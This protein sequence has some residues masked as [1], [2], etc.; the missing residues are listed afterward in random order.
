MIMTRNIE[1]N[2]LNSSGYDLLYPKTID[3]NTE[4]DAIIKEIL[5][6][7]ESDMLDDVLL[8]MVLPDNKYAVALTVK[9]PG[10]RPFNGA[11]VSGIT[12]YVG[13]VLTT[14][15]NGYVLGFCDTSTPTVTVTNPF[16]DVNGN[17][18]QQLNLTGKV[19]NQI[20]MVGVRVS[21]P[22]ITFNSGSRA[23]LFSPDVEKF[24]CSAIGGGQNGGTGTAVYVDRSYA[25]ANG[26]AGGNAGEI[27][28]AENISNPGNSFTVVVGG[29]GENSSV[30]DYI[31][32]SGG[33]GAVGGKGSY[34]WVDLSP[35]SA[36]TRETAG[37]AG[38]NSSGFL[39]P[40]TEVGGSGGGG[41]A[42]LDVDGG[43]AIEYAQNGGAP[44]G[45]KG[46]EY[47]NRLY[48]P[49]NGKLPGAGGGG[50]PASYTSENHSLAGGTGAA[51]LVGFTWTY[52]SDLT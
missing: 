41:G 44:G 15:E 23:I 7:P 3:S 21:N 32:A 11:S 13:E 39:Y 29:V 43:Y 20:E 6:L 50:G 4:V 12:S 22:Q 48:S 26:G 36:S 37:T 5:S 14:D 24:N 10:G 16:L 9:T 47:T 27:K 28:N 51:G 2:Y 46:G 1:I 17:V 8:N 34:A 25:Q 49:E 42:E 33:G 38:N 31:T 19:I 35:G 30:G 40:P 52:F 18:V 45:G